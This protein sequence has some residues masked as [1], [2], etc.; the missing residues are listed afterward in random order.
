M[1]TR[2]WQE[3]VKSMNPSNDSD[4]NSCISKIL[5]CLVHR[6]CLM[7][8]CVISLIKYCAL[9]QTQG[10]QE[11]SQGEFPN[12]SITHW[13]QMKCFD[14][15]VIFQIWDGLN[16]PISFTIKTAELRLTETKH[17]FVNMILP[18]NNNQVVRYTSF[19]TFIFY[20]WLS[21][22][23]NQIVHLF[24]KD[25]IASHGLSIVNHDEAFHTFLPFIVS[26]WA[27]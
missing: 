11:Q 4:T 25:K 26:E 20:F 9:S 7:S 10:G 8:K 3:K 19:C 23:G 2:P 14:S 27:S 15:F 16:I 22:C 13:A 1:L 24:N 21:C 5:F 17:G 12:I 18:Q 6:I